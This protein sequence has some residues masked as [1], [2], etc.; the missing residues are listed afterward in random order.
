M[1][2][3][4]RRRFVLWL[5]LAFFVLAA[6]DVAT[7]ALRRRP[8]PPKHPV[9][10]PGVGVTYE[11]EDD[12][13]EKTT[14][15][16]T[17]IKDHTGRITYLAL[18]ETQLK[19]TLT[20]LK[21]N[22]LAALEKWEAEKAR[23]EK[24]GRKLDAPQPTKPLYKYSKVKGETKAKEAVLKLRRKQA[25]EDFKKRNDKDAKDKPPPPEDPSLKDIIRDRIL[26]RLKTG[27]TPEKK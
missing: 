6:C 20:K 1:R 14:Y 19:A 7:A 24:L 8:R 17:K 23:A 18:T 12:D 9:R 13:P 4:G 15:Y 16:V 25:E 26:D 27:E 22:Y 3:D 21:T 5:L 11:D 2:Y 10:R